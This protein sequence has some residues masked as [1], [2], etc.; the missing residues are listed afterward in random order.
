[1]EIRV[2][3]GGRKS[4]KGGA[5]RREGEEGGERPRGG[6]TSQKGGAVC[7]LDSGPQSLAAQ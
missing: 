1:M 6:E 5:R 3:R 4:K 2:G 7:C